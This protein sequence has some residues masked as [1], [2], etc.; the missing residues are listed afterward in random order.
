RST[1]ESR[2][3]P[4]PRHSGGTHSPR[5]KQ[6]PYTGWGRAWGLTPT[7][8]TPPVNSEGISLCSRATSDRNSSS[9][10]TPPLQCGMRNSECGIDGRP[11]IPHSALRIPHL[12]PQALREVFGQPVGGEANLFQ[13]VPVAHCHR[14]VLGGLT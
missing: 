11:S 9:R 3:T 14:A 4:L 12:T 13:R 7:A 10:T 5:G 6:A 8:T 2:S 1:R